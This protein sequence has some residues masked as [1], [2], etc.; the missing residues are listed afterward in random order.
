MR[1]AA[2][3]RATDFESNIQTLFGAAARRF[4]QPGA[5]TLMV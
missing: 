1:Q 3:L 4:R 2:V 5:A